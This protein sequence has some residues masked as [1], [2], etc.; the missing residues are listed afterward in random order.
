VTEIDPT[1]F[2]AFAR[3]CWQQ[4]TL[5]PLTDRQADVIAEAVKNLDDEHTDL[6]TKAMPIYCRVCGKAA[7]FELTPDVVRE[8]G[9]IRREYLCDEDLGPFVHVFTDQRVLT[10]TVT[11]LP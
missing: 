7:V 6:L 4:K 10:W 3:R 2:R 9:Y 11:R 5:F 8:P 1:S